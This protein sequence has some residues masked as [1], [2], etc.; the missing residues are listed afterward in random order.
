MSIV[1]ADSSASTPRRVV[2]EGS[3]VRRGVASKSL[4]MMLCACVSATAA[5]A[6]QC[7][8]AGGN[9]CWGAG[10]GLGAAG[11]HVACGFV[12]SVWLGCVLLSWRLVNW[13]E[14]KLCERHAFADPQSQADDGKALTSHPVKASP[15]AISLR[16]TFEPLACCL[17]SA[18]LLAAA[19][20]GTRVFASSAVLTLVARDWLAALTFLGGVAHRGA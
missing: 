18:C 11:N 16:G 6:V 5:A 9:A 3:R 12:V 4:A 1:P 19:V 14:L 15:F 10:A 17:A 20:H 13:W 2:L 7:L 8:V